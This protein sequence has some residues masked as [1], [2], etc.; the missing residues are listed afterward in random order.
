MKNRIVPLAAVA[1]MFLVGCGESKNEMA[2][3][4]A[5]AN[6][7][8]GDR[9]AQAQVEPEKKTG[10]MDADVRNK[11]TRSEFDLAM[12]KAKGTHKLATKKCDALA[13]VEKSACASTA[14]A[15][16]A[17]ASTEATTTRD[18]ALVTTENPK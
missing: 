8:A 12:T 13:E 7:D 17:A 9:Y 4:V 2:S 5:D 10:A 14:D 16:L 11:N 18:A 1:A 6:K 15:V 3:D